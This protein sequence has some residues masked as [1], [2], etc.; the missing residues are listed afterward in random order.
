MT[1]VERQ[2]KLGR[3]ECFSLM[4]FSG[5]DIPLRMPSGNINPS[6]SDALSKVF[7]RWVNYLLPACEF[8]ERMKSLELIFRRF[9]P[10]EVTNPWGSVGVVSPS[11]APGLTAEELDLWR[12]DVERAKEALDV[13]NNLESLV[14][15]QGR[16]KCS[17]LPRQAGDG[18]EK[19]TYLICDQPPF[20]TEWSPNFRLVLNTKSGA[21]FIGIFD[22]NGLFHG[23]GHLFVGGC[24]VELPERR[25]ADYAPGYLEA[26]VLRPQ[27]LKLVLAQREINWLANKAGMYGKIRGLFGGDGTSQ[28]VDITLCD[29]QGTPLCHI[30]APGTFSYDSGFALTGKGTIWTEVGGKIEGYPPPTP[31]FK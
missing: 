11:R 26:L 22:S 18:T 12:S 1:A 10:A 28:N 27:E 7:P 14:T 13:L 25:K 16:I 23:R 31:D 9:R 6:L 5:P 15:R 3:Q 29:Y 20:G 21:V 24:L 8:L 19:G 30:A 17:S 2:E 4:Q